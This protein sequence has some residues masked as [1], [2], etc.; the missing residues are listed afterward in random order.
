MKKTVPIWSDAFGFT[1][2]DLLTQYEVAFYEAVEM[3]EAMAGKSL[4]QAFDAVFDIDWMHQMVVHLS[5]GERSL[6]A[7]RQ[8]VLEAAV[9]Q[10]GPVIMEHYEQAKQDVL[11]SN[12]SKLCPSVDDRNQTIEK[13]ERMGLVV[14]AECIGEF[15]VV[16]SAQNQ[17]DCNNKDY[18]YRKALKSVS[19]HEPKFAFLEPYLDALNKFPNLFPTLTDEQMRAV[20]ANTNPNICLELKDH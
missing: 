10:F 16:R 14:E 4:R 7:G 19:F 8:R 17:V 20:L 15:W 13:Y 9:R 11:E 5:A 2:D 1:Q 18:G 3:I 6:E 12:F